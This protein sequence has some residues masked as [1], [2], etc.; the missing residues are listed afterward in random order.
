MSRR[1]GFKKDEK[2]KNF[3]GPIRDLLKFAN[4]SQ[5]FL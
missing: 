5:M 3:P 1:G 4:Q 2:Y